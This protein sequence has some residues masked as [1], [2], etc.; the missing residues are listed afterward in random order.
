MYADAALAG[1]PL[2][3]EEA[4]FSAALGVMALAVCDDPR[5]EA[6]RRRTRAFVVGA[7]AFPG[8]WRY[9]RHL[10][11][12]LDSL[13]VCSLAVAEHPWVLFGMN[14]RM[15]AAARDERGRFL[16]WAQ[17][18]PPGFANA[19]DGV[20][21][22]NALAYLATHGRHAPGE[23]AAAWL[24]DV[25]EKDAAEAASHFYPSPIDLYA[26]MARARQHGVPA[27]APADGLLARR[28]LALRRADGSY[29][30]ALRTARALTA[31]A[32]LDALPKEDAL[33]RSV[34]WLLDA[35]RADGGW[36]SCVQW[37]GP[38]PPQPP[39]QGF[40]CDPLDA[41]CCVEALVRSASL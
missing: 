31:L 22:A 14:L 12:D 5:A 29:G 39:T 1:R 20:V 6:I 27:F 34:T 28:T 10:P 4:P 32:V 38:P 13:S 41:A 16:T 2:L 3:E 8:R 7:M 37:R 21:N 11:C 15:L 17:A 40:R 36:P 24:V 26:A 30:D 35:Q 33:A 23:R 25:V 18:P 9:W 19:A